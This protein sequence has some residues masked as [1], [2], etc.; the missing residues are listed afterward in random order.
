[1]IVIIFTTFVLAWN[2]L[3]G[4]HIGP[5]VILLQVASVLV[6]VLFVSIPERLLIKPLLFGALYALGSGLS[7]A[8][9]VTLDERIGIFGFALMEV[10][11]YTA[12]ILFASF[13]Q[14]L[15]FTLCHTPAFIFFINDLGTAGGAGEDTFMYTGLAIFAEF[16]F[17][18]LSKTIDD[19][20][21]KMYSMV[22]FISTENKQNEIQLK[23]EKMFNNSADEESADDSDD[24]DTNDRRDEMNRAS[25]KQSMSSLST[26]SREMSRSR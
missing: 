21:R 13:K 7:I 25:I 26:A 2:V 15:L 3:A 9:R 22:I 18:W 16:I 20:S 12:G 4:R 17:L 8:S 14:C 19:R 23:R 11:H 6:M 24:D 5:G 10:Y 1:M